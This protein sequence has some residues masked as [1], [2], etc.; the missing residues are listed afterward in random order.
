MSSAHVVVVGGGVSGLAAAWELTV[1]LPGARITVLDASDRPGG[2]LRRGRV[3]GVLVD[4]GAESLL[5]RRPEALALIGEVGA[6]DLLTHPATTAAHV[7]SR[8][9]LHPLPAGTLMGVPGDPSTALGLLTGAE[10]DR[11]RDERPWPTGPLTEDVSVG[12]YVAARLGDAVVDRLVEPL[13]GGVYAGHARRL[14]LQASVP[15][16]F[17]VARSGG[18]LAGAARAAAERAAA[19]TSP[20]F[21]GLVG[22]MGVFAERLADALRERGVDVRSNTIA[23]ELHRDGSGWEV[24]VGPVPAPERI[25]ADGVVLAVPAAP[26]ARLLR[27]HAPS[28]ADELAAI[29]YASMAIVTLA[30]AKGDLGE[31]PGSGFLVP[32]ADGRG[33]KASTFTSAKWAWAADVSD[34]AF[35]LR[36]SV[37]RA[38]ETADLQR[39]DEELVALAVRE[40]GE[41]LGEPLPRLLDAHVQRWGGGL[42]QY[43]VGHLDRVARIRGATAGLPGLQLAG[44][45]YEGVGIPACVGSGRA[46]GAAIAT[47]CTSRAGAGGE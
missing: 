34:E 10:V 38:G 43:A 4:V 24:V 23:R 16:L 47:H 11:A 22:G 20:V 40:V 17:E 33:I 39:P 28:A 35:F 3:A 18:S 2:K 7:W 27:D 6:G 36:A 19:D 12:D 31:L 37:G 1:R 21:A 46:A 42:P 9:R 25:A 44:A 14:S 15:G 41:A 45:A 29:E 32:P 30:V 13:L 26:A 5:A 8:G